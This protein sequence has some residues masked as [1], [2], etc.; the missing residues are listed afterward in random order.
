ME[1]KFKTNDNEIIFVNNNIIKMSKFIDNM[2]E[3]NDNDDDVEIIYL[4]NV[5]S[6]CFNKIIEYCTY[7]ENKQIK[8]IKKPLISNNLIECGVSE[9]DVA[10]I[11]I[12]QEFLFDLLMS[13]NYLDIDGI[14]DLACAK[15]ASMIKSKTPEEIRNQFNIE[16]EFTPEEEKF[17]NEENKWCEDS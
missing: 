15:I 11:D 5:N 7:Y 4:P 14:L 3:I 10:F 16:N 17:L 6:K 1:L 2:I 12:E 13:V 9:W 8:P